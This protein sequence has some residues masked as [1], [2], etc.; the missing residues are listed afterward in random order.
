MK[1]VLIGCGIISLIVILAVVGCSAYACH[2]LN[3]FTTG[4][5]AAGAQIEALDQK[6]PFEAPTDGRVS[7]ERFAQYMDAREGILGAVMQVGLVSELVAASEQNR[8][9]NIGIGD[10][11]GI[12][13]AIPNLMGSLA[14]SLEASEMSPK[15]FAF[16]STIVLKWAQEAVAAGD[17]EVSEVWTQFKEALD[18]VDAQMAANQDPNIRQLRQDPDVM[19]AKVEEAPVVDSNMAIVE[20]QRAR[21]LENRGALIVELLIAIYVQANANAGQ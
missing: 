8:Q 13:G 19:I 10:F 12:I 7:P 6:F 17:S 15:E 11:L 18:Q 20:G 4:I 3:Q 21:L 5:E 16:H 14:E 1:K 2:K 9:P